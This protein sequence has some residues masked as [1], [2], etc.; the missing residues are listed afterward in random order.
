MRMRSAGDVSRIGLQQPT[1]SWSRRAVLVRLG[2]ACEWDV[3]DDE[4]RLRHAKPRG[5]DVRGVAPSRQG[6]RVDIAR[7]G[8]ARVLGQGEHALID[9]SYRI[10]GVPV[11]IDAWYFDPIV[12]SLVLGVEIRDAEPD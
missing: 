9:E 5:A 4:L 7:L 8:L 11:F 12:E 3:R 10:G 1:G 6:I 2:N